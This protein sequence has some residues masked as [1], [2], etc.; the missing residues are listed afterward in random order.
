MGSNSRLW[1]LP[2][3]LALL[4]STLGVYSSALFLASATL[5]LGLGSST[6]RG[7]PI[8]GLQVLDLV[9]LSIPLAGSVEPA[10]ES[11]AH[12]VGLRERPFCIVGLCAG[13]VVRLSSSNFRSVPPLPVGGSAVRLSIVS[14]PPHFW[15][16]SISFDLRA[17]NGGGACGGVGRACVGLCAVVV[18]G[19][20]SAGG[21]PIA[22]GAPMAGGLCD[23]VVFL[24]DSIQS[25]CPPSL[26]T[27]LNT[28]TSWLNAQFGPRWQLMPGCSEK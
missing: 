12:G 6:L 21:A 18:V 16:K 20:G 2:I 8:V 10:E 24:T 26:H 23:A 13:T 15:R 17:V 7:A 25:Y 14:W 11:L 22:G 28:S 9:V 3:R 19:F 5:P 27:A 1:V 4:C